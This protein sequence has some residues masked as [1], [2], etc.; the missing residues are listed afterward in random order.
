VSGG[1]GA[2]GR[3]GKLVESQDA[4]G[5]LLDGDGPIPRFNERVRADP[6]AICVILSVRDGVTLIRR[7]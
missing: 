4:S 5:A 1:H 2:E 3:C 6:R 7:R